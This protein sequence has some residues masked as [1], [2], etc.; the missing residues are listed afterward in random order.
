MSNIHPCEPTLPELIDIRTSIDFMLE[1]EFNKLEG[2]SIMH[3]LSEKL[4]AI[5]SQINRHLSEENDN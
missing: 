4:Y 5:N 2:E 1:E 3:E